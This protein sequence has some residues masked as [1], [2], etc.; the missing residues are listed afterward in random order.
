VEIGQFVFAREME[1]INGL[2]GVIEVVVAYCTL[3]SIQLAVVVEYKEFGS[4]LGGWEG[5]LCEVLNTI[6]NKDE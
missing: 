5:G 2:S 1:D 3:V 4:G 6:I